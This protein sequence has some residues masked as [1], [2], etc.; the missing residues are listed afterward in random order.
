M[1]EP[2]AGPLNRAT[3]PAIT[4]LGY[5]DHTEY[6]DKGVKL[7]YAEQPDGAIV[8]VD[9]LEPGLKHDLI[10][11]VCRKAVHRVRN[12]Y[13][14][15]FFRHTS[16]AAG[17]GGPET[18]AHIW[19]KAQLLE[20][21]AVWLPEVLSRFAEVNEPLQD[22][23][24]FKF[25]DVLIEPVRGDLRPD[26]V[27]QVKAPEGEIRELWIEIHV[28]HKCGPRKR[29]KIEARAQATIEI[30]LSA[31]RTS[32]DAPAIRA[33]LLEGKDNREWLFHKAQA[34]DF[35]VRTQR[36][37]EAKAAAEARLRAKA[38]RLVAALRSA[39][40]LA[41]EPGLTAIITKIA[42]HG[43]GDVVGLAGPKAGFRVSQTAWQSV[44]W[45]SL[46][47]TRQEADR[48]DLPLKA[49]TALA[50][51]TDFLPAPLQGVLSPEVIEAARQ[52]D[53]EFVAPQ[54]AIERYFETLMQRGELWRGR[55]GAWFVRHERGSALYRRIEHFRRVRDR[56]KQVGKRVNGLIAQLP[57]PTSFDMAAWLDQPCL[58]GYSARQMIEGRESLWDSFDAALQG[59]ERMTLGWRHVD[60]L[61][62]LPIEPLRD[63]ALAREAEARAKAAREKA[64]AEAKEAQDRV[65]AIE[66]SARLHLG[67]GAE[68]WLDEGP[69]EGV[70]F[71]LL[72]GQS[73]G[74][75][76]RA[77][78]A[79][80]ARLREI[81]AEAERQKRWTRNLAELGRQ[82]FKFYDEVKGRVWMNG[83]HPKLGGMA[84]REAAREDAGLK[85][86]L[87]LLP[88]KPERSGH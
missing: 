66:T 35:R 76:E 6:G 28:T 49:A 30:D 26:L 45:N 34:E 43:L 70:S 57:A 38:G 7:A 60:Q 54:E 4:P 65:E 62:G 44:V 13:D 32:H 12:R 18:N 29:A 31:F 25:I 16:D 1:S 21:K 17:C 78:N 23:R 9:R 68:A 8:K 41:P 64:Q 88:R 87:A 42:E 67:D 27:V 86:S 71:R 79:L 10:C 15:L 63:A 69:S 59:I 3:P 37:E 11:P 5:V 51:L 58:G 50:V 48:G 77:R 14:R 75:L 61:L 72:A 47:V 19:A 74:G 2:D 82:V 83:S 81:E 80:W 20:A 85:A 52:I 24:W 55:E 36:V 46:V 56:M 73:S 33:A 53:A 39:R 40:M 84:P 22:A